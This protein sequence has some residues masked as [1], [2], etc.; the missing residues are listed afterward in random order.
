MAVEVAF[1]IE[2][3]DEGYYIASAFELQGCHT[4]AK[5]FDELM[6]RIKEAVALCLET[7]G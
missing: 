3:D 5:S 6:H 7:G 4:Q 2:R 1:V